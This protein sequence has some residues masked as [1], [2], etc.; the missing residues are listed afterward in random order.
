MVQHSNEFENNS[1]LLVGKFRAVV[2]EGTSDSQE[3]YIYNL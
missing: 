3:A 2:A 1:N